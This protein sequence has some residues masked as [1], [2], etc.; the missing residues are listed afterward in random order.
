MLFVRSYVRPSVPLFKTKQISSENN[1]RY[2][3]DCGSDQVDHWWHLSCFHLA[4]KK[5]S[6]T[7]LLSILVLHLF[8][9][10]LHLKLL[11][12][13]P[14]TLLITIDPSGRPQSRP[15][16]I[17]IC[18]QVVRPSVPKLQNQVTITVGRD[19]GLVEWIIDDTCL[20]FSILALSTINK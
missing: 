18:T 3:Q 6:K 10:R 8:Q 15:V 20:V 4:L 13:N 17:T 2:W 1:V 5:K 9:S 14:T 7:F 12:C 11:C 19:C 16:V